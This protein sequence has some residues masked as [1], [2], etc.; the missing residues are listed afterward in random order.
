MLITRLR[1]PWGKYSALGSSIQM[2]KIDTELKTRTVAI[3]VIQFWVTLF[4]TAMMPLTMRVPASLPNR[5][6]V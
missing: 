3:R 5:V 1:L 4:T 6:R 2:P